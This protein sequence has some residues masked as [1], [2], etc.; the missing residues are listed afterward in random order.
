MTELPIEEDKITA[1]EVLNPFDERYKE[2]YPELENILYIGGA[3]GF[4]NNMFF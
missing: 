3:F 4:Y 1:V 2:E